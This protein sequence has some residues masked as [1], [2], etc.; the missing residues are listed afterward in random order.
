M[1]SFCEIRSDCGWST[2]FGL[3]LGEHLVWSVIEL[4]NVLHPQQSGEI[5]N[6]A[7]CLKN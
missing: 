7:I 4:E 3:A 1:R 6:W 2:K 5:T